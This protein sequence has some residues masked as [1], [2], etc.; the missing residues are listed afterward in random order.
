M[1]KWYDKYNLKQWELSHRLRVFIYR[2]KTH[3]IFK[4][5]EL[6]RGLI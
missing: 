1:N 6:T 4:P 5:L 2:K 3:P